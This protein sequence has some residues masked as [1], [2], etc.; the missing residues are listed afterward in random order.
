MRQLRP[1]NINLL[2]LTL[3]LGITQMVQGQEV[4]NPSS[5]LTIGINANTNSGLIGGLNLR[6]LYERKP[7]AWDVY[8]LEI[9]N[10][11]PKEEIRA[12]TNSSNS[13]L[14]GKIKYLIAIR[15]SFGR[16]IN[17][18]QKSPEEGVRL[19]F[20]FSG[21]PT[22]G[23]LKPYFIEYETLQ[24]GLAVRQTVAYDPRIHRTDQIAGDSGLLF[25]LGS[26]DVKLGVH[27]RSA[28]NFEYGMS[29]DVTM[30]VETGITLEAFASPI[31]QMTNNQSRQ[32]YSAFF[33]HLYYGL[34]F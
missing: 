31:V 22:I 32:F 8:S 23:L 4:F 24:N 3:F 15:P 10:I 20:N 33:L 13:F 16:E 11:K 29:E 17:L 19:N 9:V 21:G 34:K 25:G 12:S 6:Y 26:S 2:L 7:N 27:T 18:F 30:G 5:E 1:I 28:L 14:L